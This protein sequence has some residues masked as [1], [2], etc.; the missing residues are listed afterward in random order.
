M[1][2]VTFVG[3][4]VSQGGCSRLIWDWIFVAKVFAGYYC[5]RGSVLENIGMVQP[6]MKLAVWRVDVVVD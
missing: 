5:C 2:S 3:C 1:H 4:K 6:V